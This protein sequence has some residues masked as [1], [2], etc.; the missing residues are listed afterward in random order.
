MGE[1]WEGGIPLSMTRHDTGGGEGGHQVVHD[2]MFGEKI[3]L[4]MLKERERK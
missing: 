1:G 2:I 3:N 4:N